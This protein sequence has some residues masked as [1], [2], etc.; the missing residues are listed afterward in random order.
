MF[1]PLISGF[2][3]YSKKKNLN[4]ELKLNILTPLNSTTDL[5]NYSDTI[6]NYI[7]KQIKQKNTNSISEKIN[8]DIFFYYG[9]YSPKYVSHFLNLK[10]NITQKC[11]NKFSK[12]IMQS[13]IYDDILVGFVTISL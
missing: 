2:N 7:S 11:I 8:Y 4:I 6:V 9:S 3:E 12:D 10:Q 1:S 13:L 5:D